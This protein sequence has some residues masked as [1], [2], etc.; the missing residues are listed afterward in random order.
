VYLYK[1]KCTSIGVYLVRIFTYL[2]LVRGSGGGL[3]TCCDATVTFDNSVISGN[4]AQLD[5]G[6]IRAWAS[7]TIVTST[8]ITDNEAGRDGAG[9]YCAGVVHF[10]GEDNTVCSNYDI[11]SY[12]RELTAGLFCNTP[13]Y[14]LAHPPPPDLCI[15]KGKNIPVEECAVSSCVG[16]NLASDGS[17]FGKG[18]TGDCP[19]TD[20]KGSAGLVVGI[21][22]SVVVVGAS[23]VA[24][25]IVRKN[26]RIV[27][28]T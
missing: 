12:S 18:C 17:A 8:Q 19:P 3:H 24:I 26:E 25:I 2:T 20:T 13:L 11:G 14:L 23:A 4:T 1:L 16:A 22:L 9:I 10:M 7:E 28:I 6:G 27:M 15:L 5:G 21:L